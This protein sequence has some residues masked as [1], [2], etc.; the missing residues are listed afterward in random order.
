MRARAR[1]RSSLQAVRVAGQ[2]QR[3]AVERMLAEW[4]KEYPGRTESIF[5][6]LCNVERRTSRIPAFDFASLDPCPRSL[7]PRSSNPLPSPTG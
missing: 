7:N 1:F 3:K 4:E 5:S 2:P 6:A